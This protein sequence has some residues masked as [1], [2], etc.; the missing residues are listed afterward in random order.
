MIQSDDLANEMQSGVAPQQGFLYFEQVQLKGGAAPL[1]AQ[2]MIYQRIFALLLLCIPGAIGIYGW[3]WMRDVFFH[4]MAGE[5][6][7][8]LP[9]AG[10]LTLFLLSLTFLGGF[11]FYRDEKRN[12]IQPKLRRKNAPSPKEEEA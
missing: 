11:L 5:G 8:W 4:Y 9:F 10:G 3:T 6:F 12:L 2:I 1:A 7:A